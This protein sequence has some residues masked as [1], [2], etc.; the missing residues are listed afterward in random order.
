MTS[1]CRVVALPLAKFSCP[2]CGLAF[3]DPR[4]PPP[5]DFADD[6]QLYAHAPGG[7]A[8]QRRQSAYAAWIARSVAAPARVL[9][10]GCG[11]GSLLLA[12]REHWPA[13]ELTGCDP[14]P[15]SVSFAHAAGLTAWT[16]TA[17][18]L[19][20][21]RRADLVVSVNVIEHTTDARAFVTGLA[22]A[23]RDD[24][25]LV[26][27]C[28]DG[29]RPGVELLI[30][31][32]LSSFGPNHL[33]SFAAS[34]GLA[35]SHRTSQG[36]FQMVVVSRGAGIEQEP[37]DP[38]A[39]FEGR[40]DYLLA[41]QKLDAGLAPRLPHEV[42]CFG[43]GETAGL[44]SAYAPDAWTRVTSCV[45][46]VGGPRFAG[47]PHVALDAAPRDATVLVGVRPQDQ[48]AVA[49]RLRTRFPCVVTWYDLV[50]SDDV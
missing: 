22:G 28:P 12:L 1:D 38:C 16:G 25:Q 13:A 44:L 32:H 14:S 34:A 31:D 29:G 42:I 19:P 30:A 2:G 50:P 39:L 10:V 5:A 47:R 8:E 18:D 40:R 45:T 37:P 48:P 36:G 20:A 4:L 33:E 9:D 26:V 6:Y 49:E 21:D 15:E 35:I 24:G 11:N 7:A 17:A 27:I 23:L 46:D 3:R 43:A 41:W